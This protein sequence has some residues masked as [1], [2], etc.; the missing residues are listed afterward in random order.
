MAPRRR[1]GRPPTPRVR[2]ACVRRPLK[3]RAPC[4]PS[5]ASVDDTATSGAPD[6]GSATV[7]PAP[8]GSEYG[9]RPRG[10]I[11]STPWTSATLQMSC[12]GRG[13]R[14]AIWGL[15]RGATACLVEERPE[16]PASR[17]IVVDD[18]RGG[19]TVGRM[20]RRAYGV[21][22][23]ASGY[24]VPA[25]STSPRTEPTKARTW[26]AEARDRLDNLRRRCGEPLFR[27]CW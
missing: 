24:R 3:G 22:R 14:K 16:G 20:R 7:P 26:H 12:A 6:R 15:T 23:R 1:R 19:A 8:C 5:A 21:L 18:D 2:A 17:L 25:R 9:F 10:R 11:D 27:P 13:D 4:A